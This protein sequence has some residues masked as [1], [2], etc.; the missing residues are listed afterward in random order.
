M[1]MGYTRFAP[2]RFEALSGGA[3]FSDPAS[4][5]TG[6]R[7]PA[8]HPARSMPWHWRRRTMRAPG[9]CSA[10]AWASAVAGTAH[11]DRSPPPRPDAAA[12]APVSSVPPWHTLAR[13]LAQPSAPAARPS[14]AH[15]KLTRALP[16]LH[17]RMDHLRRRARRAERRS[18]PQGRPT[19]R[20]ASVA[21]VTPEAI[22]TSRQPS[23][24][25]GGDQ[26]ACAGRHERHQR[27]HLGR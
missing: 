24:P 15:R 19:R 26:V 17:H 7:P 21:N 2:G 11:S 13:P 23:P 4:F 1:T 18:E 20:C 8:P 22:V 16:A 14:Q 27:P 10:D 5:P 12:G 25:L 3:T 9:S 6:D